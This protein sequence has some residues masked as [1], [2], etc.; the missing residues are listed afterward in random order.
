[1]KP[2]NKT[3]LFVLLATFVALTSSFSQAGEAH[4]RWQ[5]QWGNPVHSD[6]PPP[7]GTDYE[8]VE[9]GTSLVRKVNSAEG[10]VPAKVEP[11]ISNDFDQ[12]DTKKDQ[13][14]SQKNPEYCQRAIDNLEV[15]DTKARIRLRNDQGEYQKEQAV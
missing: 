8:V 1:M 5:D 3:S 4:Y 7:K 10:V 2:A 6:R 9:S 13:Y 11:T 12:V 15:L 14:V